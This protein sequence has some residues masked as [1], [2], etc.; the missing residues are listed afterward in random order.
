MGS[1][2]GELQR[3]VEVHRPTRRAG[4]RGYRLVL[5]DAP[6][7]GYEAYGA[8][9][10]DRVALMVPL[11]GPHPPFEFHVRVTGRCPTEWRPGCW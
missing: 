4:P 2:V 9:W 11:Y 5:P 7:I 10:S 1:R 6:L 3:I 8:D